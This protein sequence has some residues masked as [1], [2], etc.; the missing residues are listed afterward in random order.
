MPS[1]RSGCAVTQTGINDHL[2]IGEGFIEPM[3]SA[4]PGTAFED[5]EYLKRVWFGHAIFLDD[6]VDA[7]IVVADDVDAEQADWSDLDPMGPNSSDEEIDEAMA[8]DVEH[9]DDIMFGDIAGPVGA[10]GDPE[11]ADDPEL[12]DDSSSSDSD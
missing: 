2:V 9:P 6:E 5:D 8:K 1:R 7:A 11:A 10:A 12:A 4:P 3:D